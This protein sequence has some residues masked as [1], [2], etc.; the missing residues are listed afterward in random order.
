M[1]ISHNYYIIAFLFS[2]KFISSIGCGKG[3]RGGG[4]G[5]GERLLPDQFY[6]NVGVPPIFGHYFYYLLLISVYVSELYCFCIFATT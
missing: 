2:L 6:T 5:G 4:G 1:Q 3:G